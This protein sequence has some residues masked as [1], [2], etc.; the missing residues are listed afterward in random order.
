MSDNGT[1]IGGARQNEIGRPATSRATDSGVSRD[2]RR[3]PLVWG[4]LSD[5]DLLAAVSDP[6]SHASA[7][8]P[9]SP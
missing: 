7:E 3:E 4:I 2:E 6:R 9:L 5:L 1:D 8:T